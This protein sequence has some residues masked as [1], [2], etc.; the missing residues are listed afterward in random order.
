LTAG[1]GGSKSDARKEKLKEKN[2]RLTEERVNL[3]IVF[4][5]ILI[6]NFLM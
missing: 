6:V 1:G 2:K 5:Y 3:F 4:C